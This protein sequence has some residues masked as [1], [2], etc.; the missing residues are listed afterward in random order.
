MISNRFTLVVAPLPHYVD[1]GLINP[2][3]HIKVYIYSYWRLWVPLPFY[4]LNSSRKLRIIIFQLSSENLG[5]LQSS[6]EKCCLSSRNC[7]SR[8]RTIYSPPNGIQIRKVSSIC[9]N[10]LCMFGSK[11]VFQKYI[12]WPLTVWLYVLLSPWSSRWQPYDVQHHH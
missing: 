1:L 7:K 6:L 9:F 3:S 5:I 2:H 8:C 10:V 11:A 12:A 4:L